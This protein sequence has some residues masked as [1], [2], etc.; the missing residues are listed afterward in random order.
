MCH[1]IVLIR[2]AIIITSSTTTSASVYISV[3]AVTMMS[4][5]IAMATAIPASR[6]F[7]DFASLIAGRINLLFQLCGVCLY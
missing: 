7:C 2:P 1:L 6:N 3:S 5:L 4:M